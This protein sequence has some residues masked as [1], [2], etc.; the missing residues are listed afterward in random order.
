MEQRMRETES[1]VARIMADSDTRTVEA[2]R[3]KNE[4]LKARLAEKDAKE[5]LLQFLSQPA[6]DNF[7]PGLMLSSMSIRSTSTSNHHHQSQQG[8]L[9]PLTASS[10]SSVIP[11][12][13]DISSSSSSVAGGGNGGHMLPM[14]MLSI[15]PASSSSVPFT[16]GALSVE[17]QQQQQQSQPAHVLDPITLEIEK[18]RMDYLEKSK[19]L[20]HQLKDLKWEIE[21]LKLED[22]QGPYDV[23]HEE[24]VLSGE[25]KYST[26]RKIKSGSTKSR[27]AV[28][29]EL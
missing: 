7:H 14:S 6:L 11:Q 24:Q 27:V 5:K 13:E 9:Q 25:N 3:L 21:K 20:E 23:I 10:V 16:I 17:S 26:L 29:E 12:N 2:E 18:E 8:Y 15:P 1:I 22:K 28:F 4:L 19:S